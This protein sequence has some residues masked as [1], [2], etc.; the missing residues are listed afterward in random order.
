[1][2]HNKTVAQ[3]LIRYQVQ[4][5]IVVIPKSVDPSRITSNIQVFDFE[6]TNDEMN[7]IDDLNRNHRFHRNDKVSKHTH[8]PFKIAF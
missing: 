8:Y 1:M 6:L 2:R 7:I 5:G 3:I 4:R